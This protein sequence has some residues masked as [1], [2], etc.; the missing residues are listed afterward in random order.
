MKKFTKSFF[1]AATALLLLAGCSNIV[2]DDARVSGMTD[3]G[4][5][6][7]KITIEGRENSAARNASR[8]INPTPYTN[9]EVFDKIELTGVS[10]TQATISEDLS[11]DFNENNEA[12]ITLSASVWY[13]TLSAYK[14]T[15][16]A[17][18]LVLQGKKRVDMKAGV[19]EDGVSFELKS[20]GITTAGAVSLAV[21]FKEGVVVTSVASVKAGLYDIS[22]GEVIDEQTYNT[23]NITYEKSAL[24]PG[25][26]SFVVSYFNADNNKIGVYADVVA[27][28][29]GRTT[30]EPVSVPDILA[31]LPGDP[32]NFHAYRI[33]NSE[34]AGY[35]NV[36]FTWSRAALKNEENFEIT[37][38][39][40]AD[41][42]ETTSPVLYKIY[43]KTSDPTNKKEI[44][45]E[46][47]D[48]VQGTLNATTE[49]C[50]I[51]LPLG[52][53]FDASI[54][55]QN[56]VGY[57]SATGVARTAAAAN[58]S[59][60]DV[61]ENEYYGTEKINRVKVTYNLNGGILQ[62]WGTDS[63]LP[64]VT[65]SLVVYDTYKGSAK[66]LM[67]IVN[68]SGNVATDYPKLK[69][70]SI[71][72]FQ[73]WLDG[74][75]PSANEVSSY[76]WQNTAV[77]AS[78][79]QTRTSIDYEVVDVW[80]SVTASVSV[81]D[82][83]TGWNADTKT[84]TLVSQTNPDITFTVAAENI[85][86]IAYK[87]DNEIGSEAAVADGAES[88]SITFEGTENLGSRKHTVLVYVTKTDGK[89]YGD[90]V[91]VDIQR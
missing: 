82:I 36:L 6:T 42:A 58:A 69:Q 28:A 17:Q 87:I 1:V 47:P 53:L 68:G 64:A 34:S 11:D 3:G 75:S 29:P 22:T 81:T 71:T 10:D 79:T 13:L 84:F 19:P 18:V 27:V 31:K 78:Y 77:Y 49:S 74:T 67:T 51:K 16:D 63:L 52:T 5:S 66:S 41:N 37:L 23:S 25:R 40:Y 85:T 44:F 7:L 73:K 43:G 59:G 35:Y 70:D 76:T 55:A 90:V 91:Y 24:N 21:N 30:T 2:N 20:D 61:P 46:S 65:G 83:A 12:V 54:R 15:G 8:M 50:I 14:G 33:E 38:N 4:E 60:D 62:R 88:A 57:S 26:Y 48:C 39:T 56:F 72:N 32:S 80:D 45:F 9:A 86:S 89:V